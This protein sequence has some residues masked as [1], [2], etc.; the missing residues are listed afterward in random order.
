M[1]IRSLVGLTLDCVS[2][3][4]SSYTFLFS[5]KVEGESKRIELSTPNIVSENIGD[6]DLESKFSEFIWP[7]LD[8]DVTDIAVIDESNLIVI[9]FSNTLQ[10]SIWAEDP[11]IGNLAIITDKS[12]GEWGAIL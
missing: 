1:N 8:C 9:Q 12:T 6:N 10:F 4:R 7:F 3:S 5:G 11:C 2:F